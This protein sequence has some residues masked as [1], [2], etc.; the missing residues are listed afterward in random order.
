MQFGRDVLQRTA[1]Q[2]DLLGSEFDLSRDRDMRNPRDQ[3][4]QRRP[5]A[6]RFGGII[7]LAVP[8]DELVGIELSRRQRRAQ[9]RRRAEADV[10]GAG[11]FQRALLGAIG[12]LD[13]FEPGRGVIG[14][15]LRRDAPRRF[16]ALALLSGRRERHRAFETRRTGVEIQDAVEIGRE[17]A[18]AG[19]DIEMNAGAVAVGGL[20]G[21]DPKRVA[22]ARQHEI[23]VA[24][25]RAGQRTHVAA[26][27]DVVQFE[28]AAAGRV[29]QRDAAGEIEPI[30]RQRAQIERAR[31]RPA[32]RSGPSGRG[33]DRA[34]CR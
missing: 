23:A 22:R 13:L 24:A 9:Q 32:S 31:S 12:H 1:A 25:D 20:A 29:M 26:K 28:R 21:R 14:L 33:R 5:G 2:H 4:P 11:K 7:V 27:G 15:D 30:D 8:G 10:A 3:R 19:I 6:D 16:I 17:R 34:T 18:L